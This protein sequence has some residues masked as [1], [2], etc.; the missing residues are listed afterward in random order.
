MINIKVKSFLFFIFLITLFFFIFSSSIFAQNYEPKIFVQ[1]HLW[2]S[3]EDSIAGGGSWN[4]WSQLSPG[5][6]VIGGVDPTHF[7]TPWKRVTTSRLGLP[8]T[9]PYSST[10][11]LDVVKYH[12]QLAKEAGIDGMFASVYNGGWQSIFRKHL[13]IANEVGIKIAQELYHGVVVDKPGNPEPFTSYPD[14]A[15]GCKISRKWYISQMVSAI[16]PFMDNPAFLKIDGKPAVWIADGPICRSQELCASTWREWFPNTTCP[17]PSAIYTWGSVQELGELLAEVEQQVGRPIYVIMTSQTKDLSGQSYASIPQ[18]GKITTVE[19]ITVFWNLFGEHNQVSVNLGGADRIRYEQ[20]YQSRINSNK[21]IAGDKLA[22]HI[23]SAFDE[24]G[25]FP[26]NAS[27]GSGFNKPRAVIT[28]DGNGMYEKNDGFLKAA[29]D[30]AKRNNLWVFFESWNDWGEQH[31]IEPGFAFNNFLY[32]QD[33]F[34]P[35]RRVAE[36]K[37][38]TNPNFS[39]PQPSLLDPPLVKYCRH[40]Q[41]EGKEVKLK[42]KFGLSQDVAFQGNGVSFTVSY[43]N[44]YLSHQDPSWQGANRWETLASVK[45]T[46]NGQLKEFEI[47]INSILDSPAIVFGIESDGDPEF[48]LPYFTEFK[49]EWYG[50]EVDLLNQEKLSK[51]NWHSSAGGLNFGQCSN[52]GC[53]RLNYSNVVLEDGKSYLLLL[54]MAPNWNVG[55]DT[56]I[57]AGIDWLKFEPFIPRCCPQGDVNCDNRVNFDDL[58]IWVNNYSKQTAQGQTEA[59]FNQDQ[60]VNTFDFA[61][62]RANYQI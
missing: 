35:L 36:F 43:L 47:D 46:Y 53:A 2:M 60:K 56:F 59:D 22:A 17:V 50:Q 62:W 19:N 40:K 15:N 33:Y 34:S 25:V 18:V 39:F 4:F 27:R 31:Q 1:Y 28:R 12:F 37:N 3:K 32:H 48:D 58:M 7:I 51:F 23:Y 11:D 10:V 14:P 29:L 8:I 49:L 41:F 52:L 26:T 30:M 5:I 55:G 13:T 57:H 38:I 45:K 42:G 24:R 20:E 61:I 9:G 21:N 54:Q 44:D 6:E 16:K